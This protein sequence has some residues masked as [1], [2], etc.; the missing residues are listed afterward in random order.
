MSD[1][2]QLIYNV[3]R[4]YDSLNDVHNHTWDGEGL[5]IAY[6]KFNQYYYCYLSCISE[7]SDDFE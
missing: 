7:F 4:W 6:P 3:D 5:T 2:T 1:Y